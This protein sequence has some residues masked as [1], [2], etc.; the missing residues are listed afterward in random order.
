MKIKI[1]KL[2]VWLKQVVEF[3]LQIALS[4]TEHRGLSFMHGN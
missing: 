2:N 4:D 3:L 1:N